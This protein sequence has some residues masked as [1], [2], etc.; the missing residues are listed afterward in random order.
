MQLKRVGPAVACVLLTILLG[1]SIRSEQA[2]LSGRLNLVAEQ[3]AH[4]WSALSDLEQDP[5]NLEARYS[6]AFH[7][8]TFQGEVARLA[9]WS[10]VPYES[11][12]GSRLY[13]DLLT[14]AY[15]VDAYA[16]VRTDLRAV[17]LDWQAAKDDWYIGRGDVARLVGQVE[18]QING[19]VGKAF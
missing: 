6:A 17:V 7:Y 9:R 8:R 1:F 19:P 4:V 13:Q 5:A 2:H 11:D 12:A 16:Q 14:G 18:E 15:H 3:G 10:G